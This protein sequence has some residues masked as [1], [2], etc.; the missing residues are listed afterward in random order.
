MK[1]IQPS[2]LKS[3]TFL[4]QL[5]PLY[6]SRL[7]S[8]V[9]RLAWGGLVNSVAALFLLRVSEEQPFSRIIKEKYIGAFV[10]V[11]LVVVPLL[12]VLWAVLKP[13]GYTEK[14][15]LWILPLFLPLF[16]IDFFLME[17]AG[18]FACW[19]IWPPNFAL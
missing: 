10:L 19:A 7:Y 15:S 8:L 2:S 1:T 14:R 12:L 3:G 13:R 5:P 16:A 18:L 11:Q 9:K 4:L 6:A 17:V